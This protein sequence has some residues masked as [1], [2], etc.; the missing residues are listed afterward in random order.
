MQ[1]TALQSDPVN[2][3]ADLLTWILVVS[4]MVTMTVAAFCISGFPQYGL[5]K[6]WGE[7]AKAE[8]LESEKVHYASF[9]YDGIVHTIAFHTAEGEPRTFEM[10]GEYIPPALAEVFEVR[11]LPSWPFVVQAV[12]EPRLSVFF[13]LSGFALVVISLLFFGLAADSRGDV[14]PLL[15]FVSRPGARMISLLEQVFDRSDI[16]DRTAA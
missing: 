12:D 8:I 2:P 10:A 11:Y 1:S 15:R 9:P 7:S 6:V 3:I 5:L 14:G 4:V 13:L 16:D